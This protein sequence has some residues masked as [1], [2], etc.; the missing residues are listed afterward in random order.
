MDSQGIIL[1]RTTPP[2]GEPLEN[3][4]RTIVMRGPLRERITES[5]LTTECS[6]HERTRLDGEGA[7]V[8]PY[9]SLEWHHEICC[10]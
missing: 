7:K 3:Y 8:E 5:T 10:S 1:T 6:I 9:E 4:P 2:E